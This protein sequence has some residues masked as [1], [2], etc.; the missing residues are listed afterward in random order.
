MDGKN[1]KKETL[2]S[3][4]QA[5]IAEQRAAIDVVTL[6]IWDPLIASI[7]EHLPDT[8]KKMA[9]NWFHIMK[10]AGEGVDKVR[11]NENSLLLETGDPRLKGTKYV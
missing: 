5:L 8:E 4:F 3:F 11:K 1:R 2:D 9:F 6:G 7:M 10:H